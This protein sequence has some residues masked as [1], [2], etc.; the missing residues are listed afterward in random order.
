MR[1]G[2]ETGKEEA[3]ME[4]VKG[5]EEANPVVAKEDLPKEAASSVVAL[6]GLSLIHI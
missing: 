1:R 5:K 2:K 6:I 4:R 3:M